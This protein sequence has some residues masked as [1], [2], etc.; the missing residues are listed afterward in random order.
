[1]SH[2]CDIF[3]IN[4]FIFVVMRGQSDLIHGTG[5]SWTGRGYEKF[6]AVDD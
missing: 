3:F 5:A 6:L 1:M 4:I 2:L